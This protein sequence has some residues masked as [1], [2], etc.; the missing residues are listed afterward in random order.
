MKTVSLHLLGAI[1]LFACRSKSTE[2]KQVVEGDPDTEVEIDET[3]ETGET[4]EP[5][6]PTIVTE[7]VGEEGG[8]LERVS[9]DDTVN[10]DIPAGA[11]TEDVEITIES[12]QIEDLSAAIEEFADISGTS[13]VFTPH[14]TTFDVGIT[15]TLSQDGAADAVLRLDDELDTSWEMISDVSFDQNTLS[16]MN[17]TF[18]VYVP[19]AICKNYCQSVMEVC[20]ELVYE[21]C[22]E[23]CQTDYL[24]HSASCSAE[25]WENN[26]CISDATRI[27]DDF[28]CATGASVSASCQPQQIELQDCISEG[29]CSNLSGSWYTKFSVNGETIT[30]QDTAGSPTDLI[31][32]GEIEAQTY[33]SLPAWVQAELPQPEYAQVFSID[34]GNFDVNGQAIPEIPGALSTMFVGEDSEGNFKLV[35]PAEERSGVSSSHICNSEIQV[36]DFPLQLAETTVVS[37]TRS[38]NEVDSDNDGTADWNDCNDADPNST[39]RSEDA[40]CD[41]ILTADDCDDT[42]SAS[43]IVANDEDCDGSLTADDCD[44][45]DSSSTIVANDGDCDDVLTADD[46]DDTDP[47]STIVAT[48]GDCDG[49]LTA[50]DC[51]DG[52]AGA[53]S[54]ASDQDCDGILTA[55][56]CDDTDPLSTIVA[57]DADCDGILTALD[58]DD[59]DPLSMTVQEDADCN[60]VS[61]E[62]MIAAGVSHSC[63]LTS[64]GAATCWGENSDGQLNAPSTN[65]QKLAVGS[66]LTCGLDF[67][68]AIECWGDDNYAQIS[69][70]PSGSFI[71]LHLGTHAACAIDTTGVLQC[72]GSDHY[73]EV[74][75]A[76]TSGTFTEISGGPYNTCALEASGA[77]QCWG[78]S[79]YNKLSNIPSGSFTDISVGMFTIC[80]LDSAGT[81]QCW[82]SDINNQI[83]NV[84]SGTFTKLVGGALHHCALDTTGAIT[85]WGGDANNQVSGALSIGTYLAVSAG[86]YHNCAIP[87]T[88]SVFCWGSNSSAQSSPPAGLNV[89][90]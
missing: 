48:D 86:H 38:P 61:N 43:T 82:G 9:G 2:E 87:N 32:A 62:R 76:P 6:E 17:N 83:S 18:S 74:S 55:A 54:I 29:G 71:D 27:R 1:F 36:L 51:D 34:F 77:I 25:V 3:G 5:T 4:G 40:D 57:S 35:Y 13:W 23:T 30:T 53:V 24:A 16:F 15:F 69:T 84:P 67:A 60:G 75:N 88:G 12:V 47:L 33:S 73:S 41:G 68:G 90:Y 65:F 45:T 10:L 52:D 58:C 50:D 72:W 39:R 21:T 66:G 22:V 14:G 63:A 46:C 70:A 49:I 20:S 78:D 37:L 44:D 26:L 80:A 64:A 7:I 59:F 19:V 8:I 79:S 56:D 89:L 42:D 11:L 28:D 85:C 81:I 31:L